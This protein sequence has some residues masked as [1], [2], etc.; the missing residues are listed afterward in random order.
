MALKFVNG[1]LVNV[2]DDGE[3]I[4]V[5][6]DPLVNFGSFA[7]ADQLNTLSN[8]INRLQSNVTG[9]NSDL[10]RIATGGGGTSG[11]RV[12]VGSSAPA[13]P[14]PRPPIPG[15]PA[16]P[17]VPDVFPNIQNTFGGITRGLNRNDETVRGQL[18]SLLQSD[19]PFIANA[20]QRAAE[21]AN[22]RGLL[23]SSIAAGAG[24]RAAIEAAL[25]IAQ[26]DAK[27]FQD[28]ALQNQQNRQQAQV[29]AQQASLQGIL[30]NQSNK[31]QDVFA[32]A[33]NR[34]RMQV[35]EFE[36]SIREHLAGVD[37][38]FAVELETLSKE[39]DVLNRMTEK[40][41]DLYADTLK[42]LAHVLE[43]DRLT[44]DQQG[45]AVDTMLNQLESGLRFINGLTG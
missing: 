11:A 42:S 20:R 45:A 16:G 1:T 40:S 10:T 23:N 32:Q 37:Q 36:A 43:N 33:D 21:T 18:N 22:A 8:Q 35:M 19:S 41:G 30:A 29:N 5:Q 27:G 38:R 15:P 31:L 28:Q 34:R 7:T 13:E 9:L 25:P 2:T 26:Q 24:E 39:Y 14:T 17:S 12:T 6:S 3:G 4:E 44:S